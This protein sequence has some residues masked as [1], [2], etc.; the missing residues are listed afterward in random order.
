[1]RRKFLTGQSLSLAV[2]VSFFIGIGLIAGL[3]S[4]TPANAAAMND[5]G[6]ICADCH[7]MLAPAFAATYHGRAWTGMSSGSGCQSCHGS[8]D[9]HVDDP[10]KETIVSY[11]EDGGRTTAELNEQC[12]N[13]H[14]TSAR[15]SFWDTGSH[16]RNDVA[17]AS[18]HTIHTTRATVE[19]PAVC[20]SCHRSQRGQI[21]K[22]SHHPIQEGKVSCSD[23][24][25]PHGT[26]SPHGMINAENINQLCY[27]CHADK[28]GPFVFEHPPVEENCAICHAPHGSRHA[29]LLVEK[30][31]NLCQD[32]H[33]WSRHPGTPYDADTGFI[34]DGPSNR[35]FG[36]SCVNCHGA[37]HGSTN[38]EQHGLTR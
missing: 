7:D 17:C 26:Q 34:G 11:S 25:N 18:C 33:S 24:H 23:C 2:F 9:K 3:V 5:M 4:S 19:E 8:T 29:K 10:S 31:P 20:F 15:L 21:N 14:V 30:A 6:G 22:R 12:L 1:M 37:I 35:F 28:R 13:C 16:S 32:C 27:Q 38:F 36:R